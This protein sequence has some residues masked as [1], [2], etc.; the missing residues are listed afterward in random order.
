VAA[1]GGAGGDRGGWWRR[2]VAAA[3]GS[4][5]WRRLA[6]QGEVG[7]RRDETGV[8]FFDLGFSPFGAVFIYH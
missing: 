2:L 1:G 8:D 5:W 3:G 7:E 6:S 4:G